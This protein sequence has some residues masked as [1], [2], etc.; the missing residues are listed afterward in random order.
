[1]C[2]MRGSIVSL[3]VRLRVMLVPAENLLSYLRKGM[4][5]PSQ[6]RML[7]VGLSHLRVPLVLTIPRKRWRQ[8]MVLLGHLRKVL[9]AKSRFMT[10]PSFYESL[11][12]MYEW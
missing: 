1:M 8:L 2:W 9:Y 4:V 5:R 10:E 11:E 12:A 7:M 6:V 3:R